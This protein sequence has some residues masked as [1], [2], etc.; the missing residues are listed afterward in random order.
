MTDSTF[1]F[2]ID[3]V[4]YIIPAFTNIPM[5][6]L[7]KS[8]HATDEMDRVFSI[9]EAVMGSDSPELAAIDKM[10]ATEF[11]DFLAEWTGGAPVG[12]SSSS[13]S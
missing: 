9:V 11:A 8:R 1:T 3:D 10:S 13:E 4:E 12:E 2:F 6:V 5:G 7:R